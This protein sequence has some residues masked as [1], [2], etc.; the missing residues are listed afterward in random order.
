MASRG[1]KLRNRN[2]R[3]GRWYFVGNWLP[4]GGHGTCWHCE[5]M[6]K[7]ETVHS[8][9][10]TEYDSYFPGAKLQDAILFCH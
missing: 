9:T 10:A 2:V 1:K 5:S 7:I 3:E 8:F 6:I 4:P